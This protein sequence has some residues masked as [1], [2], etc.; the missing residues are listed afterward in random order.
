MGEYKTIVAELGA[1]QID[2]ANNTRILTEAE[3]EQI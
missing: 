3:N 1:I 2:L